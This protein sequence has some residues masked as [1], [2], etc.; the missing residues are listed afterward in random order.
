MCVGSL[1]TNQPSNST[2]IPHRIHNKTL[3]VDKKTNPIIDE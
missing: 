2:Q 3:A 1:L